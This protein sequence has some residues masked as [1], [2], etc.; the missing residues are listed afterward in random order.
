MQHTQ[1]I[2][3]NFVGS[4]LINYNGNSA[5]PVLWPEIHLRCQLKNETTKIAK[6][7]WCAYGVIFRVLK[8]DRI[9]HEI[10]VK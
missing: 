5:H 7:Y 1:N 8:I 4:L 3:R 9:D 6:L 10:K 2:V